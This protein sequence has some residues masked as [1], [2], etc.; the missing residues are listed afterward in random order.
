MSELPEFLKRGDS[1]VIKKMAQLIRAGAVLTS[2]T[3]PVCGTPLLKLK[4]GEHYCAKCDKPV[5][6]VRSDEEEIEVSMRYKLMEIRSTIF[7]KIVTLNEVLKKS[8]EEDLDKVQEVTR[9]L[10]LLLEA[11]ERVGKLINELG[12]KRVERG[13]S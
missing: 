1:L 10:L 7:D 2:Y 11:F 6:I 8:T 4:S 9:S 13:K 5:V 3:C 12:V